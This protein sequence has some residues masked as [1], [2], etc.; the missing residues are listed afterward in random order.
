MKL[1]KNGNKC[2]GTFRL[3]GKKRR[4]RAKNIGRLSVYYYS[5]SR[6]Y[7]MYLSKVGT[8]IFS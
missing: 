3:L 6:N 8:L 7:I 2:I 4:A 5:I 1:G